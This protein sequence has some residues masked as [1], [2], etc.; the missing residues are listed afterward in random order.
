MIEWWLYI[1]ESCG[2]D[3]FKGRLY[4]SPLSNRNARVGRVLCWLILQVEVD[5]RVSVVQHQTVW[6]FID[7]CLRDKVVVNESAVPATNTYAID[8]GSLFKYLEVVLK[9]LTEL[10]HSESV[11]DVR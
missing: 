9:L 10:E 11:F 4:R 2:I 8:V 3:V 6:M 1:V 5:N 7:L